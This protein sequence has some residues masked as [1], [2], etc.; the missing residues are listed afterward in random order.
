VSNLTDVIREKLLEFR[1]THGRSPNDE[2]AK[3]VGEEAFRALRVEEVS[4]I[5]ELMMAEVEWI[6]A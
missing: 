2:E 3:R 4:E 1:E 6:E 5:G